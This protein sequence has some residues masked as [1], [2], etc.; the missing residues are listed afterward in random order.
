MSAFKRTLAKTGTR[1]S[2][3]AIVVVAA[4]SVSGLGASAAVAAP[5][6]P[7]T[8]AAMKTVGEGSSLQ[9]TAQ[10]GTWSKKYNE[11]CGAEDE[12]EYISSSS[13]TGLNKWSA[14]ASGGTIDH[15]RS[16]IGTDDAPNSTQLANIKEAGGNTDVVVVPVTQAAI[17][18]VA[19]PPATCTIT[20]ITQADLQNVFNGTIKEWSGISTASGSC[21][22]PITR[23]VRADGS[24]TSYQLKH[25]LDLI[26][27]GNLTCTAGPTTWE[28]L[29]TAANNTVWPENGAGGC[30]AGTVSEVLH[31]KAGGTGAAGT[32]SGGGDEVKTINNT[33]NSIGYAALADAENN[34]TG[35][36]HTLEVQ[37]GTSL[38][39]PTYASPLLAEKMSN[40]EETQYNVPTDAQVEELGPGEFEPVTENSPFNVD[41]SGVYGSGTETVD[42]SICTLTWDLAF[43]NYGN[44][45]FT[46]GGTGSVIEDYFTTILGTGVTD[47][48][49]AGTYYD[50]IPATN[51]PGTDVAGAAAYVTSMIG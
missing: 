9:R 6:C 43:R 12:I 49:D 30:A 31:S 14:N 45:G 39:V 5:S 44:A 1:A 50:A 18:I 41:W 34:K 26:N 23:V 27:G 40:C 17:A 3:L 20:K 33:E 37:N 36:T 11:T 15:T 4:L 2:L 48:T 35:G 25:F 7:V 13:G 10:I 8:G 21:G 47:L 24:G 32:G 28:G 38:G 29:Q 46:T 19:N 42:Y 51:Q 22:F 16:F